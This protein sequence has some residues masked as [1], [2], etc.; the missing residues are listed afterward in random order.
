MG[1]RASVFILCL[2]F[3]RA[4]AALSPEAKAFLEKIPGK[5]VTLDLV[6]LRAIESSD[7]FRAVAANA[8]T[9]ENPLLRAKAPLDFKLYTKAQHT[10]DR[11]EPSNPFSFNSLNSTQFTLGASTYLPTGTALAAELSHGSTSLIFPTIPRNDFFETK[12][13]LTLSQNL[14]KDGLGR[15]TR[16]GLEAGELSRDAGRLNHVESIENWTLE[17]VQVYYGAWLAQEQA[18]AALENIERRKRLVATTKV[19]VNRGTA[20]AADLLQVENALLNAEVQRDQALQTLGNRWRELRAAIKLPEN[21]AD[22]DPIDIPIALDEPVKEMAEA[23]GP[24]EALRASPDNSVATE[25]AALQS[26]AAQL[27]EARARNLAAPSLELQGSVMANGIDP[28]NRGTTLSEMVDYQH[29]A[30]GVGVNFTLPLRRF[31]EEAGARQAVADR[32]RAEAMASQARDTLKLQWT[33]YCLDLYRLNEARARYEEAFQNQARRVQLESTRFNVG[34]GS[35]F[36]IVQAGDD[37]TN[38]ELSLLSSEA[39]LRLA[40]W[41]V[42]RLSQGF[43]TYYQKLAAQYGATIPAGA[44]GD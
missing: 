8:A 37:A 42:R 10:E 33:Q 34:R 11:R 17:L 32:I 16:L 31:E 29:P 27:A 19:R 30:W 21:L 13:S 22:V 1:V 41:R 14:W 20:E 44:F 15:A 36:A 18:K 23:C 4:E 3:G 6:L 24:R 9:I 2:M 5:K 28:S 35:T 7:S 43:R 25:K 26:K 38:T 40:A 39:E 12:G